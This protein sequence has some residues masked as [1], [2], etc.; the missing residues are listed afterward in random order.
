MREY[1]QTQIEDKLKEEEKDWH[2]NT[3]QTV[4]DLVHPSLF[5]YVSN[6]SVLAESTLSAK[7]K[8]FIDEQDKAA[9]KSKTGRRNWF[10]SRNGGDGDAP[11]N[12]DR[13]KYQW[14]PSEFEI[15][16][17]S[18]GESVA[19]VNILSYIN[20]LDRLKH[21]AL[22]DLIA[23]VFGKFVPLFDQVLEEKLPAKCQVIVKLANILLDPAE[24]EQYG[25]GS[26]HIE[27]MEYEHIACSGIYYFDIANIKGSYL[28]FRQSIDEQSI[29]YNQNDTVGV[30]EEYGLRDED[31]L[32]E[33]L[34]KIAIDK[35]KCIAFPNR[36]QHR[37]T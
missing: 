11:T 26:W 32:N 9:K 15:E 4:L 31:P 3:N 24:K 22:Y 7:V 6:Q 21:S 35:R 13:F 28:Q 37:V 25:G 19:G 23:C 34:G 18:D 17:G 2:P 14:L 20:N 10:Y 1:V 29:D 16:R 30:F 5:C 12:D 27:G 36:L 33:Y 8:Q